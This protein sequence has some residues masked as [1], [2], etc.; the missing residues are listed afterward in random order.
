[1]LKLQHRQKFALQ[2][3]S[4]EQGWAIRPPRTRSGSSSLLSVN[5]QWLSPEEVGCELQ[6]INVF[7]SF[8]KELTR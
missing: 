7:S 8:L 3:V 2:E 6:N 1:M 5:K 4:R